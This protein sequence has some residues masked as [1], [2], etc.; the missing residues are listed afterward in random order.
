MLCEFRSKLQMGVWGLNRPAV[1]TL[2]A[3]RTICTKADNIAS[4]YTVH[5]RQSLWL[6]PDIHK[7]FLLKRPYKRPP[8]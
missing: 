4:D 6:N 3:M 8:L 7:D 2:R 1:S 5:F